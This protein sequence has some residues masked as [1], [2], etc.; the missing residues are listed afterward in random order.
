MTDHRPTGT[1][2]V[3]LVVRGLAVGAAATLLALG[4]H[5]AAAGHPPSAAATLG[6]AA[7]VSAVA[8]ALSRAHWTVP[9]LLAVLLAAQAGLHAVFARTPTPSSVGTHVHGSTADAT[10][11]A[12]EATMLA[13]HLAAVLL[14]AVVLR[15]GEQ[16]LCGMLDALALRAVRM[17]DVPLAEY[18]GRPQPVPVQAATRPRRRVTADAWWERGPPR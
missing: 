12:T 9:R 5:I 15:R 4:G 14:T 7:S 3:W 18:G 10:L 6:A 11:A 17:L 16:W 8:L 13:G 1:H 2:G